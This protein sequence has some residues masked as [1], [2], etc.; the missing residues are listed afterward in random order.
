[1]ND[2]AGQWEM[3]SEE[4]TARG[5]PRIFFAALIALILVASVALLPVKQYLAAALVWTQGLGVWGPLFVVGFYVIAAVLLLPGSILTLGAGFLFGVPVGVATVWVGANLGA[6]AAFLVG[7]TV[8]RDWV[9]RKVSGNPKFTAIDDAVRREGFKI[10]FLLRLSPVFPFN[11]LNYALG[12]TKVSFR[13][14]ALASMIGMLPATLM[15]V[16][17]GSAARSL[18]EVVAGKVQGGVAGQ[19]FFWLGLA[20]TIVV[21]LSVTRLAR[22][23]LREA[24]AALSPRSPAGLP[25]P[26]PGDRVEVLPE[27]EHNRELISHVHPRDWVHPEPVER[28]NL[29]VIGAGTAGLVTAAGAAGLGAKVALVE[30]HLMGGDCLN[31][32]CVPSKAL[33]RSSR[34]FAEVR[35]AGKFG[36]RVPE[37]ASVDFASVMERL[38]RLRAGISHHDSAQRFKDLG[39]DVFLGQARF[40]G[41]NTIDVDGKT[42]RFRKAVITTGARAVHPKIKGLAEAGFL[43]NETVF[44]LTQRPRRFAVIGGGPIGCEMAQAFQRLG[45]EVILFHRNDHILDREDRDAAEIIQ[46]Q[47]IR[48][49]IR[50]VLKS[51][52]K[53]VET[54]NGE[55]VIHFEVDGVRDSIA[56]DEILVGAGRAPNV[57][58]LNLEV[59]GVQYD[60][61]RGVFVDDHLQTTNPAIFAAGDVSM[62]Y[63]F[64][65]TAD[66]AARI[67]IQ[68]AL[69]KGTKK[70]SALTVPWCTYTDPE[71][72]HVGLYERDAAKQG[73]PVDTFV[74]HL[75][76]VDRARLDGEDAGFVK[77]HVKK[78]T[79]K[80]LGAT[81]VAAHAGEMISELT[82]AMVGKVGL[83]TLSGVIHPY[84]TQAD[85]I[86]QAA[87]AYNRTR[88]TPFVKGLFGK[89]LSWTR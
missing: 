1:M 50:L 25:T 57:E 15:Y 67:V 38:R 2:T 29:V 43:T 87:D 30:R 64:T 22:R 32:G 16:Y 75:A 8:A 83:G 69:F 14:Y 42:L 19:A 65:H 5:L 39:V 80:I 88:L 81:I 40:A 17:F 56:V 45:S 86:K 34:V 35:D 84:P 78:G 44:A 55:K 52:P 73:T 24:E 11:F 60:T 47:F 49:G 18:T 89:W 9:A 77:I 31:Y 20:A 41:P 68:N 26:R 36:I 27:D 63:K 85:A 3:Q 21:A 7:R 37:G 58:D 12:L 28:Y 6:L 72:A 13:N 48:E 59:A 61:R 71:I 4:K 70:L 53:E 66:A 10:V 82:L 62:M 76:D 33:I 51:D 74:R 54:V 79:D 46:N 23:S